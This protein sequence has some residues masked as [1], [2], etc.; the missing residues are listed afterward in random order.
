[1]LITTGTA[2]TIQT[3]TIFFFF[4]VELEFELRVL[5]LQSLHYHLSHTSS[6]FCS[7]YFLE[8]GS[9]KLFALADLEP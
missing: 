1:M 2:T 4:F 5:S 7:G 9:G 3:P 6:P 8:V